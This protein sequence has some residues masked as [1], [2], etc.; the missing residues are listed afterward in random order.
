MWR[1]T[2]TD[3]ARA[4]ATVSY[5]INSCS[6]YSTERGLYGRT[7]PEVSERFDTL[8]T[9]K[10][11]AFS[12]WGIIFVGEI[13]G[14]LVLWVDESSVKEFS[15]ILVP[16]TYACI[17]QSIWCVFFSREQ[18]FLSAM[19][20]TGIAY[21]LKLCSD[22]IDLNEIRM[23]ELT[24]SSALIPFIAHAL[25]TY[26]IRIHFG[27]TTAAALINWN[28]F[29]V[30]FRQQGLEVFPA[31][32][33]VWFAASIAAFR[34]NILGDAIF[35]IVIAWAFLAMCAKIRSSPPKIF[36]KDFVFLE[37]LE[38]TFECLSLNMAI[39]AFLACAT[40]YIFSISF[41]EFSS[42]KSWVVLELT[43]ISPYIFMVYVF[44]SWN[45]AIVQ[46]ICCN[47]GI[48]QWK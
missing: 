37:I 36:C 8:I 19:A 23:A 6:N 45:I 2:L 16:F 42:Y 48:F 18:M 5:V 20:L 9:P 39:A 46:N 43:D 32:F 34:A 38:T 1:Q 31:L 11:W 13:L 26:P 44:I 29:V 15:S 10:G 33:S 7:N 14:L 30:S 27:W 17:L 41:L 40:S 21:S 28:M 25:I 47:R 12:I 22:G 4:S 24:S 35:A 3:H